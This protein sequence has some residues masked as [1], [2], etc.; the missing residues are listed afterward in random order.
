V[1]VELE[2]QP[3]QQTA[4]ED[5]RRHARVADR[6]EQDRV[7]PAQLVED[8]VREQLAG[9]LPAHRPEV[10]VGGLDIGGDLAQDLQ[11]LGH[12]LGADPVSSDHCQA[13]GVDS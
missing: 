12:H 2:A 8:R 13:H 7:V 6:S 9:A 1:V 5:P 4:L 11:S 3:Q 10:V